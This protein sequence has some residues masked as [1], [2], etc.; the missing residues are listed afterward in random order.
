MLNQ[1]NKAFAE[2]DAEML[3]RQTAWALERYD[4]VRALDRKDF[5]TL[6]QFLDVQIGTAGGK[7]WHTQI[8]MTNKAMLTEFVAKN[9][10]KTI[11]NRNNRI[12]KALGKEGVTE[13]TEFTLAHNG[14]GFEGTFKI[15]GCL[16]TI[17]TILAGGYNIQCLHQRTLVKVRKEK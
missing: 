17:E 2:L 4:A 16:V 13:I 1:I 3:E 10:A 6:E 7:V 11:A 12:V 5:N 8:T 14:N 15:A 9:V